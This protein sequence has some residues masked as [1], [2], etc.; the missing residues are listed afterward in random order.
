MTSGFL[1]SF[2]GKEGHH[3]NLTC[4]RNREPSEET[5]LPLQEKDAKEFEDIPISNAEIMHLVIRSCPC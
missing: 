3:E 5:N 2:C 1:N 4:E